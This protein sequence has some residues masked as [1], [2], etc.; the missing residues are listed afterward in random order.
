M[1]FLQATLCLEV[2]SCPPTI[3]LHRVIKAAERVYRAFLDA[4]ALVKWLPPNG[5]PARSITWMPGPVAITECRLPI[6]VRARTTGFAG[7]ILNWCPMSSFASRTGSMT[8]TCRA[9]C[10]QQ[11]LCTECSGVRLSIDWSQEG[12]QDSPAEQRNW[13]AG[14]SS[15]CSP[16][17]VRPAL[18]NDRM[19]ALH[20]TPLA[21]TPGEL[22]PLITGVGLEHKDSDISAPTAMPSYPELI[23]DDE[24]AHTKSA[25]A[26]H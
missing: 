16:G 6:P 23:D 4:D 17:L 25:F 5:L 15:C 9:S 1:S 21:P 19:D 13:L 8:R 22:T 3:R 24:L 14:I 7:N 12:V 18:R 2:Q 20:L 10:T 26:A 11:S